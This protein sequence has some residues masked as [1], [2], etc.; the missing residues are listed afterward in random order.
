MDKGIE[1]KCR[2]ECCGYVNR[3]FFE[4]IFLRNKADLKA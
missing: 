1:R 2:H 4:K 3:V